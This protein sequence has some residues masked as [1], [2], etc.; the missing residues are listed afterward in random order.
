MF[1]QIQVISLKIFVHR[2]WAGRLRLANEISRIDFQLCANQKMPLKQETKLT[3][4]LKRRRNRA[5]VCRTGQDSSAGGS[6]RDTC[7][8]LSGFIERKQS[9]HSGADLCPRM[10]LPGLAQN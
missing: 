7:L 10:S 3:R 1:I 9:L 8:A 5:G 2:L 4:T 6:R